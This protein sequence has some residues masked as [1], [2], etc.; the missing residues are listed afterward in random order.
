MIDKVINRMV[1]VEAWNHLG[2]YLESLEIEGIDQAGTVLENE[3][4][5]M[6]KLSEFQ[7]RVY[8]GNILRRC[9]G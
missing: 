5:N 8:M 3:D 9:A 4:C 2:P 7:L 1:V 6:A